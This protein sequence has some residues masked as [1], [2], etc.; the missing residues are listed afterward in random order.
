MILSI[1]HAEKDYIIPFSDGQDLYGVF[2]I[3]SATLAAMGHARPKHSGV[4]GGFLSVPD[5][6]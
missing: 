6:I 3:V 1:R 5:R 4:E 2:H